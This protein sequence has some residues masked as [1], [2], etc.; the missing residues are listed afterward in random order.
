MAQK[1]PQKIPK[2]YFCNI[3]NYNTCNKKDFNKHL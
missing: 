2:N 1:N 3:C